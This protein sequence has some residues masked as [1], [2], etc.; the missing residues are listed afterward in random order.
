MATEASTADGEREEVSVI[1]TGQAGPTPSDRKTSR[2]A[3]TRGKNPSRRRADRHEEEAKAL[4]DTTAALALHSKKTDRIRKRM[5]KR[6]SRRVKSR[7]ASFLD[8]PSEL[9]TEMLGYLL[10][11]DVFSL[12][13]LNHFCRDFVSDNEAAI[14]NRIM[15]RRYWVLK[16][17]FPCPIPLSHVDEHSRLSLTS[18]NWQDRL[19]I[20]KYWYQHIQQIDPTTVCTCMTCVLAW[21]NLNIVL[22]LAHWQ[23]NLEAR[24]PLPIIPR[25]RTPEWNTALL[26]A[27]GDIV[28]TAMQSPLAHARTLQVHLDTITRTII[29]SSKWRKKGEPRTTT[30][31]RLYR[32][33]DAE[34]AAGNDQFLERSGP[35]SYQPI[36]MRDNYYSVEAFVPNRKWDKE[37]GAWKYY[38]KWPTPHLTDVAWITARFSP[39]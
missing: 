31:P 39:S 8:F 4:L 34:I 20:H 3:P 9:L 21:N 5:E 7:I 11:S 14:A 19:K 1:W 36:Y 12:L 2:P 27:H 32:L 23:V 38:S 16:Q 35:P 6:E 22:D 30:K 37:E 15:Q 28:R 18:Q 33:T 24:E 26:V 17:C 29:R 13:R 10:P 25:G